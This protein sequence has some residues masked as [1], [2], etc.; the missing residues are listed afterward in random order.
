MGSSLNY[1]GEKKWNLL[2]F[3]SVHISKKSK[4]CATPAPA[5]GMYLEKV[6]Y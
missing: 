5:L 6:I 3:N 2:K 1:L 4:L